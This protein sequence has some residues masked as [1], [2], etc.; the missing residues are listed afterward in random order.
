MLIPDLSSTKLTLVGQVTVL[1]ILPALV[2][3]IFEELGWRGF[4]GPKIQ[5]VV[6]NPLIGHVL[7]GL[8]WF[9]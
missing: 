6:S 8:V 2:K 9:A 4:L 1:A 3:N 7:V 5:L